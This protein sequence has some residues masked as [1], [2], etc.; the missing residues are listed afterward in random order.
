MIVVKKLVL[1]DFKGG[2]RIGRGDESD[3]SLS[4]IHSDTI[5]GAIVYWAFKVN[6]QRAESFAKTF[7]TSSLLFKKDNDY[8]VP[9]PLLFDAQKVKEPKKIKKSSYVYLSKLMQ[10]QTEEAVVAEQ[11]IQTTKVSRNSLDRV[12]NSSMFY[13]VEVSFVKESFTPCIV[14]EFDNEFQDLLLSSLKLLG[15]SGLGGDNTYGFG[16]FDF[17]ILD[18]PQLF[19]QNG[20]YHMTLSLS[21]PSYEE[22]SKLEKGY[23]K[24]LRKRGFRKDVVK[25]K[26]DLCYLAEGS[27]FEFPISGRGAVKIEDYFVQTSPI[28]LRFGGDSY[29]TNLKD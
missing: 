7:R 18:L 6:S 1:L 4:T 8:V 24:I 27:T 28:L 12:T 19:N 17:H 21:I 20:K 23:Y 3:S 15:D 16:L 29:E 25:P 22:I 10:N 5:Y 11:P 14:V 13:F 2:F 26:V 9:K